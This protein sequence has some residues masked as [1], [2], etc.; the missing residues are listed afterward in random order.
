MFK[1]IKD[2]EN[3]VQ[4]KDCDRANVEAELQCIIK[5]LNK[6]LHMR[7]SDKKEGESGVC[8]RMKKLVVMVVVLL[9][10]LSFTNY[11]VN[12]G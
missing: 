10:V 7:N 5:D 4:E 3:K 6:K 12:R 8:G 1:R 9:M 2:L 11:G